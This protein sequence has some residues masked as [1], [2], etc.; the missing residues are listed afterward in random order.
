VLVSLRREVIGVLAAQTPDLH[1]ALNRAEAEG[2]THEVPL[3]EPIIDVL[4][5][6]A[7]AMQAGLAVPD[8]VQ[9][10]LTQARAQR[11]RD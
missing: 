4:A 1:A 9:A 10:I 7:E 6:V 3:P 8:A 2:M 5:Q 11:G